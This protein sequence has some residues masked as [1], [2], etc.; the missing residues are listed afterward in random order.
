MGCDKKSRGERERGE[1]SRSEMS[2]GE[3]SHGEMEGDDDFRC[4]APYGREYVALPD[5]IGYCD[6]RS[7]IDLARRCCEKDGIDSLEL[8]SSK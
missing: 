8:A 1:K 2:Q 6:H 7:T 5:S 4:R 3:E